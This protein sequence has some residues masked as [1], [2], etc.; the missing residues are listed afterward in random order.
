[1]KNNSY[2]FM[3]F[4]AIIAFLQ[5]KSQ[6]KSFIYIYIQTKKH[7]PLRIYIYKNNYIFQILCTNQHL[8]V[9]NYFELNHILQLSGCDDNLKKKQN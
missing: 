5:Q 2:L 1:M 8:N 3:C 7:N 4:I 9:G 6:Q